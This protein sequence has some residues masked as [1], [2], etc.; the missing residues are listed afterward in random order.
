MKGDCKLL[1]DSYGVN[2]ITKDELATMVLE[3]DFNLE[4]VLKVIEMLTSKEKEIKK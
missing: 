4:L 1:L 3:R 2:D